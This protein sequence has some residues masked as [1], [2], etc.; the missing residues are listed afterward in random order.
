MSMIKTECPSKLNLFL[1]V[2]SKRNDGYHE[3]ETSFQLIDLTDQM[4]FE[5]CDRDIV[6]ESDEELLR[7]TDNTIYKSAEK[8]KKMFNVSNG[9][10]INIKKN[11]PLGA[12]LGGG[13]SN[14]AT[15]IVALNRL[16]NLSL[17]KKDMFDLAK[18][19]GADVPLFIYGKNSIGKGIGEKLEFTES[20]KENL[21]LICPDIQNSTKEMFDELDIL[22]IKNKLI[23][24]SDQNDFWDA[25]IS[26]SKQVED[27]YNNYSQDYE[28]NLSG[29]GSCIY[30]RFNK[31]NE[32]DKILKKIPTNWRLF[33]CKPLQYSPICYI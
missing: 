31:K 13:S 5:I 6:I 16:W 12:G 9:A 20:I 24:N 28:L 21:L 22:R 26:R 4:T 10:K 32:I 2:G 19:I 17:E 8:L 27:F 14:A 11:I 30:L 18:N 1:K 3:I 33:F 23:V 25:Y 29:S 7:G 15:T